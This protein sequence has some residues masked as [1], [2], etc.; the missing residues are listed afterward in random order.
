[1]RA[2]RGDP[3]RMPQVFE[4]L[5]EHLRGGAGNTSSAP[6]IVERLWQQVYVDLSLADNS[7]LAADRA[8]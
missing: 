5:D 4:Q 7:P 2:C 1:M 3:E 6:K 8:E